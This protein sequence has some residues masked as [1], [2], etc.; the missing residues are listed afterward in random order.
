MRLGM[1]AN[2]TLHLGKHPAHIAVPLTALTQI[3]GQDT[4]YVA[5]R[6]SLKVAPRKV[7]IAGLTDNGVKVASGLRPGDIVVTGGVQFLKPGKKVKLPKA[8]MKT[9]LAQ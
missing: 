7:T 9:A 5:D 2:A 8:V 3:D 4:V 1:T 6:S